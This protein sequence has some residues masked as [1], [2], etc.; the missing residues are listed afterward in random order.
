M[1]EDPLNFV[2]G[3]RA[4]LSKERQINAELSQNLKELERNH[5]HDINQMKSLLE[6]EQEKAFKLKNL[7]SDRHSAHKATLEA[8]LQEAHDSNKRMQI[9]LGKLKRYAAADL[10]KKL[11]E[12]ESR[13]YALAERVKE[14]ERE[15]ESV[16][17]EAVKFI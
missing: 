8:Q 9:E 14:L 12:Q 7:L 5:T 15:V 17:D 6:A 3:F 13:N 2:A 1:V 10:E 16:R 4:E 11:Q